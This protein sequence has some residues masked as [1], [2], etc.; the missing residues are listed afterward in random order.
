MPDVYYWCRGQDDNIGDVLLRRR[1][2]REL[3]HLGQVHV[4]IGGA[5]EGFIDAMSFDES[6]V[7]HRSQAGW[8]K[9]LYRAAIRRGVVLAANPGEVRVDMKSALA[10]SSIIPAQVLSRWRGGK[11][12]QLG[13]AVKGKHSILRIPVTIFGRNS[14]L[15]SFR[16]EVEAS[17]DVP[18]YPDW[19]FDE[20]R[21]THVVVAR[22]DVCAVTYRVDRPMLSESALEALRRVCSERD[23]KIVVFS[24]VRRDNSRTREL[25]S[26]LGGDVLM[27]EDD[28]SHADQER[29]IRDLMAHSE[30]VVSDRIHALIMG[31][32][33]G[34][35]PLGLIPGPD[36]KVGPH[37]AAA[38]IAGI[39]GEIASLG[40]DAVADFIRGVIDRRTEIEA[41]V[42]MARARVANLGQ[43]VRLVNVGVRERSGS[44]R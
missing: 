11:S 28:V 21:D 16:E 36:V 41:R 39:S 1:F 30:V 26:T 19:A 13:V 40:T 2:L 3:R 24:Q 14:D 5:S 35:T 17:P 44:L 31:T 18:V 25:A 23:L 12:L 43:A 7:L 27:W 37:F 10:Y 8:L 42:G 22:R 29:K 15:Q 38:S 33:E 20:S 34:A 32:S 4:L 6:D 9:A